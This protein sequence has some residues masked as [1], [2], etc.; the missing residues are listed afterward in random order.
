[1][2]PVAAASRL[3]A[4]IESRAGGT[5]I[6]DLSVQMGRIMDAIHSTVPQELWPEILRKI[7]GPVAADAPAD[8]FEDGD[9]DE[10]HY[11]L[12]EPA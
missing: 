4:L 2:I 7:D 8:E 10:D 11:D 12:V 6:A 3:Q 5:R 1:M 9:D